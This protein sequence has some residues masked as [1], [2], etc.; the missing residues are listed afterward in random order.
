MS[1]DIG[2]RKWRASGLISASVVIKPVDSGTC[3]NVRAEGAFKNIENPDV[4]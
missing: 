4:E 3:G 1:A 2:L